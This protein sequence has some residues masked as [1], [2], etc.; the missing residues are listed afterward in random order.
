MERKMVWKMREKRIGR[1]EKDQPARRTGIGSEL[2]QFLMI[3]LQL[4]LLDL[5]FL[6]EQEDFVNFWRQENHLSVKGLEGFD[7][8]LN[9]FFELP[10]LGIQHF[11]AGFLRSDHSSL[12]DLPYLR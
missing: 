12:L 11:E 1:K 8:I 5:Q 4:S 3:Q 9:G 7:L 10:V 6:D 2:M